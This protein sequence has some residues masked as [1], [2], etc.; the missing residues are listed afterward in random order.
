MNFTLS[1]FKERDGLRRFAFQCVGA[2]DA[3]TTVIVRA[4]VALARKHEI[5]LQ[6]LPLI[7]V[8]LLESMS[9][10]ELAAPITL[11]EDHMIAIQ[12]AA[13]SAAEKR[14]QKPTRRPTPIARQPWRSG[15]P[16]VQS[17]G[18]SNRTQLP[19]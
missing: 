10:D 11:T 7:C 12:T 17:L 4:D 1:G 18:P 14:A 19:R 6:E 16:G 15:A 5:R 9:A 8:R 3:K 13:R 2:N